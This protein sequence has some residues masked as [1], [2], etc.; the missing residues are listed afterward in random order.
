[1]KTSRPSIVPWPVTTPSVRYSFS[2][3]RW[4]P[5]PAFRTSNSS[6]EPSSRSRSTRSRAVSF[7]VHVAL[8]MRFGPPP[9]LASSRILWSANRLSCKGQVGSVNSGA[10]GSI[11]IDDFV[12]S[13]SVLF[14]VFSRRPF[15]GTIKIKLL[16]VSRPT[17]GDSIMQPYWRGT[18]NHFGCRRQLQA[19]RGP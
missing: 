10:S 12:S 8:S 14:M 18:V 3:P 19:Q 2:W 7:R 13:V 4:P 5:L 1:M 9:C 11:G 15:T 6:K 16:Q 17:K